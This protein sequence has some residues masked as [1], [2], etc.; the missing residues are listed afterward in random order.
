MRYVIPA[1]MLLGLFSAAARAQTLQLAPHAPKRYV[2]VKG[3]T[4]WGISGRFLKHPWRWPE[5]WH[6][7]RAEI[8]NPHWIYPG[9][10]IVLEYVN[11]EPRLRL[12]NGQGTAGLEIVRLEPK[13]RAS[14]IESP[15]PAIPAQAIGPFLARPL[16]VDAKSLAAAPVIVGTEDERVILGPGDTAFAEGLAP[17]DGTD[18]QIYRQGRRLTD[19]QTHQVLGY[20]AVY[21]GAARVTRFGHPSTLEITS[22]TQEV[23]PG[24]RLIPTP[25]HAGFPNFVPQA[26]RRP[27]EGQIVSSYGGMGVGQF[28]VIGIDRGTDAGLA[29][30]DVLAI[31]H[32]GAVV[33]SLACRKPGVRIAVNDHVSPAAHYRS[34]CPAPAAKTLRLPDERAGLAMVFRVFDKV[35]Y[36]LVLR[37]SRP[38]YVRDDV[39]NP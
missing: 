17:A 25:K 2:V 36:A 23:G 18:F 35:S 33:P 26:P 39:K 27:V 22:V 1:L 14:R 5:I 20:Q 38:I 37:A 34:D 30:G 29:P 8:D 4:L 12:E 19:P 31:Y 7:N 16:L 13:I 21:L 15:I 28:A 6:M 10:V 3:D 11:G 9:N 24:D 32:R